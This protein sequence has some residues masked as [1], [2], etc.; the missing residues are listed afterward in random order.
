MADRRVRVIFG[1]ED[2]GMINTLQQMKK[3]IQLTNSELQLASQK[4]NTYG[5]N[6]QNLTEKKKA[7]TTQIQNVK[8]QME[9]YNQNIE[10][11]SRK[12]EENKNKLT[13]L[14]EKKKQL[15]EQIKEAEK[16]YGKESEE[17]SKLK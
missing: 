9:L 2:T 1:V 4:V 12:Y 15:K 17:V 3:Q 8:R 7:L 16:Q 13:E 14:T 6:I 5:K 11:N 10:N